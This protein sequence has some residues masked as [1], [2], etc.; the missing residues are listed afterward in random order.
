M[1]D[2]PIRATVSLRGVVFGADD[3][4]LLMRRASDGGWELPGGRLDAHEDALAGLRRELAEET[5]LDPL[6]HEPVHT[7][8]WRNDADRGRFAVYYLCESERRSV[9]LSD[10]HVAAEWVS[11]ATARER[12]SGSQGTAVARADE[13]RDS[14]V[15]LAETTGDLS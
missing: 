14:T 1:T 7:V 6:V 4:V 11:V 13:T 10:E 15:E 9:S 5:S 12:L 2:D 3:T 8:S